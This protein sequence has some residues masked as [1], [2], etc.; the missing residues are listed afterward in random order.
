MTNN[1]TLASSSDDLKAWIGKSESV[2]DIVTPRLSISLRAILDNMSYADTSR[3]LPQLG[4]WLLAPPIVPQ[5]EIGLDGHPAVGG[6]LP[7]IPLPRRMWAASKIEFH[8]PLTVGST[9]TRQSTIK[10]VAEKLGSTGRLI[11]VEVEHSYQINGYVAVSEL[12]TIVYREA[13][14]AAQVPKLD[15]GASLGWE[16]K[17]LIVPTTSQLFRYSAVTF[18]GHRIHY[19]NHYAVAEEGYPS[20]IVHGPLIATLLVNLVTQTFGDDALQSFSF[21]AVSPGYVDQPMRLSGQCNGKSIQLRAVSGED[22]ILMM[23]EGVLR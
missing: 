15:E 23:A 22:R 3:S 16:L 14:A 1:S 19:D 21:R 2:S 6:F 4:H 20:L 18:N 5:K 8:F 11:F 10:A 17:N 12:Q 7:P 9:V 13:S